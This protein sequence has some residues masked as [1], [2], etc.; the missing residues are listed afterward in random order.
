MVGVN[1]L[2]CFLFYDFNDLFVFFFVWV[3]VFFEMDGDMIVVSCIGWV[4][5]WNEDFF[6]GLFIGGWV[7]YYKV[8][9]LRGLFEVVFNCF[10]LM[11]GIL[12]FLD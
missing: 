5:E 2:C 7:W 6:G 11:R 10:L 4:F 3:V 1:E 8:K 12:L 9:F